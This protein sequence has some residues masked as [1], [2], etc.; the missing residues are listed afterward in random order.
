MANIGRYDV[1]VV[2]GGHAGCEAAAAAARMGATTALITHTAETIG[3]MSC[4]PAIGGI[5]KGHLVREID[6]LDGLMG[7]VADASGIQFRVLNRSKGPAVRGPRAQADR[8]LYRRKMRESISLVVGLDVIE[9][10]VQDIN[11]NAGHLSGLVLADGRSFVCASAVI[12]TGTFLRGVMHC[13]REQKPGGRV[14]DQQSNALSQSFESLGFKL[15]RLK[16]GTPARLNSRSIDWDQLEV[17]HGDET[18]EPFSSL[19]QSIN[20]PQVPCHIAWTNSNTHKIIRDNLQQSAMYSGSISGR[21]PRYCPSI[22]DKISRFADRD[23][24]Q[25]FLEP[26]GLDNH[27]IYPNGI[28]TSLPSDVQLEFLQTIVGLSKVS[29][30]VYGYAIEYDY[31][32]PRELWPT[33]ET[34]RLTGLFLAGQI[35]GT[36]GYEEAA[37][38]GLL[39]GVNAALRAGGTPLL[40]LSRNSSYIG[41]MVDDLVTKG[42][43]EPY[44]MFT[45]RAEYRLSLRA[46]NADFRLTE[47]GLNVGCVGPE[48]ARSFKML[49]TQFSEAESVMKRTFV[50][51]SQ[52]DKL[53]LQINRDGQ[54]RSLYNILSRPETDFNSIL[55]EFPDLQSIPAHVRAR[56]E[57]DAK[58]AVY[59]DRQKSEISK[60]QA[61]EETELPMSLQFNDVP[62]LSNEVRARLGEVRP[63]SLG[64]AARIEGVTPAAISILAAFLRKNPQSFEKKLMVEARP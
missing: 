37:A 15:G 56:L 48:R 60:L 23:R 3:V 34:K 11:W 45:S 1:I 14:G 17:Q 9:G 57:N 55:A 61:Q 46:D 4:N 7:R 43:T 16:T 58:Y 30:L 25:V 28:S 27:S 41:V 26:E 64:Q 24:H 10:E 52:V 47:I 12:T 33:L 54:S 40:T 22:E 62:G 6:A 44:R 49:K 5:G 21:G 38:Q 39:A 36:T 53:G 2:G 31:I 59:L 32:D 50:T 35:N 19:T 51:A 42:V 20:V 18:P 13:G 8:S 63:R 29:V